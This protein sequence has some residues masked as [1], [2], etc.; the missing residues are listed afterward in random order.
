MSITEKMQQLNTSDLS[1]LTNQL[2]D[3][4]AS[5]QQLKSMDF[6]SLQVQLK[7]IVSSAKSAQAS[8]ATTSSLS[9]GGN[10]LTTEQFLSELKKAQR[11]S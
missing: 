6:A 10:G 7:G 1:G 3:A 2:S 5:L 4:Q 8:L 9:E 11:V